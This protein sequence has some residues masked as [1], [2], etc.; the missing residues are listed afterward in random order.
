MQAVH[1][2]G[3]VLGAAVSG[4][5]VERVVLHPLKISRTDVNPNPHPALVVWAGPVMGCLIPIGVRLLCRSALSAIDL[6][7]L[8]FFVG[9]CLVANGSYLVFGTPDRIGDCGEILRTGAPVW[10]PMFTGTAALLSGFL[11]WHRLGSLRWYLWHPELISPR[12]LLVTLTIL[13]AVCM[14]LAL[15]R[16]H[17]FLIR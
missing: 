1:E 8:Q 16:G 2:F 7:L 3:H 15:P 17:L 14:A 13:L 9:F 5:N 6:G 11:V 12:R 4:G 10:L